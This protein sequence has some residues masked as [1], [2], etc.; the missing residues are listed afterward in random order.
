MCIS[1]D[2]A[3][4]HLWLQENLRK[5]Q[6]D[7]KYYETGC[8][9]NPLTHITYYRPLLCFDYLDLIFVFDL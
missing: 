4:L 6:K 5:H 3:A 8:S 9:M 2:R 1:N 7:S